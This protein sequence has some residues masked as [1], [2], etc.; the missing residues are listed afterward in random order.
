MVEYISSDFDVDIVVENE[1]MSFLASVKNVFYHFVF[2]QQYEGL[3]EVKQYYIHRYEIV[4]WLYN[5]LENDGDHQLFLN[6]S[7][8]TLSLEYQLDLNRFISQ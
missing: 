1:K 3:N 5:A 4:N 7:G 2:F 6:S 8:I